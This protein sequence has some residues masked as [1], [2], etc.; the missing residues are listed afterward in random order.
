M[1]EH[2]T[3]PCSAE[4]NPR[5]LSSTWKGS[6][7]IK[8]HDADAF[9]SLVISQ[10]A[11]LIKREHARRI[12][13]ASP[14]RKLNVSRCFGAANC[15]AE[16]IDLQSCCLGMRQLLP[17]CLLRL[18]LRAAHQFT[19]ALRLCGPH[20]V[21]HNVLVPDS[22]QTSIGLREGNQDACKPVGQDKVPKM[23]PLM[24]GPKDEHLL[25][26]GGTL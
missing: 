9:N 16:A 13:R 22:V 10:L 4:G 23:E 21:E 19:V 8:Y 2:G 3:Y 6:A 18:L 25:L 14:T 12:L 1:S 17:L 20:S 7:L 24:N 26:S 15:P 5:N 11:S